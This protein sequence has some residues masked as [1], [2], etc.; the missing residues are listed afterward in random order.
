MSDFKRLTNEDYKDLGIV[1]YGG[2][3]NPC[4]V[5]LTIG[6][7]IGGCVKGGSR[8]IMTEVFTRLAAYEDTALTP[9]QVAALQTRIDELTVMLGSALEDMESYKGACEFCKYGTRYPEDEP[10]RYCWNEDDNPHFRW[11]GYDRF[12][13]VPEFPAKGE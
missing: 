13:N 3:L 1:G 8:E 2:E 11:S 12:P 6:E 9:E 4:I 10:C 5:M 7:L